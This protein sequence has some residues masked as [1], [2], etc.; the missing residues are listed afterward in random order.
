LAK[1]IENIDNFILAPASKPQEDFL[2]STSTITLY[3]GS[4]GAGKTFAIILSMVKFMLKKNSTIV[5]F[6]RNATQIKSGGGIWQEACMVF[7]QM[8][9]KSVIIRNRDLEIY[10]PA[11]NSVLKFSHLQY[12]SDV[13]NFL[14]AQLSCIYYDEVTTFEPFEEFVL[15][16]LGRMRNANVDYT[17]QMFLA[18]NPKYGHGI[19]YWIKDFYLDETGIPLA[20][21]SNIERYFVL[22][23]SSPVWFD[24]LEDAQAVYGTRADSGIRSF[25][26]I[27]AHVSDNVKLL[28]QNPEYLSNLKALPDIKRRIYLDGSWTAREEEAGLYQ[29]TWS[30]IVPY[31][32]IKAT[33]RVRAWD[34][35]S[36]PVSTQTPNPDWTRGLLMSKDKA[37]IYTA[38]DLVSVRDRPHVVEELIYE[39]ARRDRDLYGNV[40]VVYPCDPGQAGIARAND[41]KRKLAEMGVMCRIVRPATSKR[42]RFLPFSAISEAGY[43]QVVKADWNE[44]FFC[45]LEEFTGLKSKERDDICDTCSDAVLALSKETNLPSF[46]LPEMQSA[47]SFG[48]QTSILPADASAGI[49]VGFN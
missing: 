48:F 2:N 17:P 42:V 15:P 39:T 33:S 19:Y 5:C 12:V 27:R 11:T 7:R 14:G 30:K 40:T 16:L 6:R 46:R 10:L 44:T 28:S 41:I 45:E 22:E 13:N 24:K 38:E 4:A 23:N 26:A 49:P 21:K 18:T 47:S 32:N 29:R 1:R 34:L 35:A 3:A 36:Q 31:P 43:M 8:F 37:G 25:R 9:G 20:E